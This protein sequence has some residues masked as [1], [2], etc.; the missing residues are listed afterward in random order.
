M[1]YNPK[2]ATSGIL[3]GSVLGPILFVLYI[4]DLPDV[5]KHGSLSYLFA[6]DMKI[7]HSIKC[8]PDCN[9]IQEEIKAMHAGRKNG[10]SAF[11]QINA[12]V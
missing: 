3:P 12:N 4:N 5:I 10:Y 11:I 6:D 8:T 7:Y 9:D 2:R 1:A